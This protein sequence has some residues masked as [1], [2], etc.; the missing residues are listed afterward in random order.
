MMTAE[1]TVA[2]TMSVPPLLLMKH[3]SVYLVSALKRVDSAILTLGNV[4]MDL[5]YALL[6]LFSLF[7]FFAFSLFRFFTFSFFAFFAFFTFYFSL[8]LFLIYDFHKFSL[9]RFFSF[10]FIIFFRFFS[11][12]IFIVAVYICKSK[13][14]CWNV[15]QIHWPKCESLHY[16]QRLWNQSVSLIKVPSN[17]RRKKK[18]LNNKIL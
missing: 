17:Y 8:F 12:L 13:W 11:V 4:L 16:Q 5:P 1:V 9:F 3:Q 7:H 14:W 18:L 2:M 15:L 6:F 10:H